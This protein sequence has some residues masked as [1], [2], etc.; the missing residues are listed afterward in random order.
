MPPRKK[1]KS[2][3]APSP[4]IRKVKVRLKVNAFQ[5]DGKHFKGEIL[6]LEETF[7]MNLM[8]NGG[9]EFIDD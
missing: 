5:P 1:D 8:S 7:A 6:E 2:A 4:A 3:V 9:A